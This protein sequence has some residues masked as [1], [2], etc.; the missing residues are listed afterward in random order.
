MSPL[1]EN[2]KSR[3]AVVLGSSYGVSAL[4]HLGLLVIAS[5]LFYGAP[6]RVKEKVAAI[7]PR[8]ERKEP[9]FD[10]KRPPALERKERVDHPKP[11]EVRLKP[12]D[13]EKPPT[14]RPR[15]EPEG[16]T[17]KRL[18]LPAMPDDAFG[19][20]HAGAG[21]PL[22]D[23]DGKVGLADG[24][25]GPATEEIVAGALFWLVRHQDRETGAW[26]AAD[27][28]RHCPDGVCRGPDFRDATGAGPGRG[29]A[30]FDV[31]VTSL[32]VLAFL[33]NGHTHR[34]SP[35]PE[36]KRA[37]KMGLDYLKGR[38]RDDGSVGF[39]G[40][41]TIYNHAIATLALCEAYAI[42]R[43]FTL[44]KPAQRAVDF[45]V[46][47][48]NPGLGWKYGVKVGKN[49][50]S[51]TG[52]FVLALKA[53]RIADLEVPDGAFR[54]ALAWIDRATAENG[55]VG[56][57]RAGDGGSQIGRRSLPHP[58]RYP[59]FE[60]L[61]TMTAVGVL[62]RMLAGEKRTDAR[63]QRGLDLLGGRLPAWS[64]GERSAV[65]LYYWYYATYAVFQ[66]TT[67]GSPEW[68]RWNEAMQQALLPTVRRGGCEAGSWDPVDEWGIVGGRVYATALG[69]LTLE[70]YYRYRRAAEG[71]AR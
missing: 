19:V 57:E 58:D 39:D 63:V 2:Q 47:A 6:A 49:D 43:D 64:E 14:D 29:D 24:G 65:N 37:V 68:R 30:R 40:G 5:L 44:K 23:R 36:F 66:A 61:P 50:T 1:A 71:T 9:P 22:G 41:E 3:F 42:S 12:L 52:W 35:H 34:H 7:L 32:A 26:P 10:R 4:V 62:C 48:Q 8:F 54:G 17:D 56:Y 13:E 55:R 16:A 25:G 70:I 69:A 33:G 27:F 15:G 38:Q 45:S 53:A 20:G 21:T 60:A 59:R 11:D 46:A 51:V 31:G 18:D 67:H 28:A